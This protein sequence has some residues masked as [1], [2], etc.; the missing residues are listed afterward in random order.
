MNIYAKD[1]QTSTHL[2][3]CLATGK[4][5]KGRKFFVDLLMILWVRAITSK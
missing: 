4:A 3:T 1:S 5:Q 2:S